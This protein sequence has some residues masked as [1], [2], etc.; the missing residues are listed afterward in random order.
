[1]PEAHALHRPCAMRTR[2]DAVVR[3]RE[4]EEERALES[5]AKA[6]ARARAASE[7][8]EQLMAAA[9]TDARA[10]GDASTW[11]LVEAAQVKALADAKRAQVERDRLQLEV[12]KV[13]VVYTSA[14]QKAEVVRRAAEHRREDQRREEA[15]VEDKALDEV[16]SMLWF[17]RAG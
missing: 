12:A 7:R 1:M 6:E 11:Q 14:H 5:V 17:R 8:V 9:N 13:R 2:L 16:A 3:V 15:R 4:R 10:K